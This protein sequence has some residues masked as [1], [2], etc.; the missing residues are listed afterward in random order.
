MVGEGSGCGGSWL[1][2][3]DLAVSAGLGLWLTSVR[4]FHLGG[5]PGQFLSSYNLQEITRWR[6]DHC[7][8]TAAH[9][10]LLV[11]GDLEENHRHL[12]KKSD[13]VGTLVLHRS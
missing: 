1:Y 8:P 4:T 2:F 7:F 11:G 6:T 5:I 9:L 3:Q 13:M 10:W 12:I